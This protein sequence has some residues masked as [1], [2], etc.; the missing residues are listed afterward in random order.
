MP[1]FD[2][3]KVKLISEETFKYHFGKHYKTYLDNLNKLIENNSPVSLT[4]VVCSSKEAIFN[5][6]AQVW[7]H[8]F[9]WLTLTPE[10]TFLEAQSELHIQIIHQYGSFANFKTQFIK[11]AT[12]LFGSG[13]TWLVINKENNQLEILNTL[14]AGVIA[15]NKFN[16]LLICDV[17]EHAYYIDYR[18]SRTEYLEA[19]WKSINWNFVSNNYKTKVLIDIDSMVLPTLNTIYDANET[20]ICS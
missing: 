10:S 6:A 11:K 2:F 4:E 1:K 8:T 17:W 3:T 5:N 14:N 15:F 13:W 16:P 19:F 20:F 7:N 9:Y 12:E 18:N